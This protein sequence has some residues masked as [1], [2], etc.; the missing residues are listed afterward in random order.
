[1]IFESST[2]N[3]LKSALPELQKAAPVNSFRTEVLTIEQ[4]D[5]KNYT[6]AIKEKP[7]PLIRLGDSVHEDRCHGQGGQTQSYPVRVVP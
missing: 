1:M 3:A 5:G 2:S 4:I 6:F 7:M